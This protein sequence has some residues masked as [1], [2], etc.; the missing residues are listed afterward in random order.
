MDIKDLTEDQREQI[1]IEQYRKVN[2]LTLIETALLI[3]SEMAINANSEETTI[4]LKAD[5]NDN[6]YKCKM[7]I[8]YEEIED[9][10][11]IRPFIGSKERKLTRRG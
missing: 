11:E 1:A 2:K 10:I 9:D 3:A 6:R 8:T 4:S 5:I 7:V